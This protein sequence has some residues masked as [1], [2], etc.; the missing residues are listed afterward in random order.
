MAWPNQT[1]NKNWNTPKS[2]DHKSE[3]AKWVPLCGEGNGY[4]W[5]SVCYNSVATSQSLKL[6]EGFF[7]KC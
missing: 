3:N 4:R 2:C 1:T 6:V 5:R 7:V